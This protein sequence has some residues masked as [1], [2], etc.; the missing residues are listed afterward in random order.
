MTDDEIRLAKV[1]WLM[2]GV[3]EIDL[4]ELAFEY[5]EKAGRVVASGPDY[6]NAVRDALDSLTDVGTRAPSL[7]AADAAQ[8]QL[9]TMEYADTSVQDGGDGSSASAPLDKQ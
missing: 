6:C 2:D 7:S 4:H 8:D 1:A 3:G 5:A 9:S